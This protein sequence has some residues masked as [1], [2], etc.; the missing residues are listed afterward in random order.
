MFNGDWER[1]DVVEHKCVGEGCCR[2]AE[3]CLE[4]MVTLG[5]GALAGTNPPQFP[6]SRW[7]GFIPAVS[8]PLLLE[9]IHGLLALT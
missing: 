1:T 7:T 3:H 5:V 2:S 6:R 4:K 8:W 9:Y